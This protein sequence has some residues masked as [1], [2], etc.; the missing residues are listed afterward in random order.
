MTHALEARIQAALAGQFCL[1]SWLLA[2][3]WLAQLSVDGYSW[4]V[5]EAMEDPH[6]QRHVRYLS[7]A[8][9][10]FPGVQLTG[11]S[12]SEFLSSGRGTKARSAEAPIGSERGLAV[13]GWR[14]RDTRR[15]IKPVWTRYYATKQGGSCDSHP[16]EWWEKISDAG[17]S[18]L[19][20]S[21]AIILCTPPA[22]A[23]CASNFTSPESQL[24]KG[25][26]RRSVGRPL[27]RAH[28]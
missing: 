1:S 20:R 6:G 22:T 23:C 16:V 15:E 17:L 25:S 26:D 14:W 11:T 9:C 5:Y 10:S 4:N 12:R 27:F 19:P 2:L 8:M 7:P 18:K 21:S 24:R 28:R 3:G 13:V